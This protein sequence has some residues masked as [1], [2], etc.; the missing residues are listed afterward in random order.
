V[1]QIV[2]RGIAF[3]AFVLLARILGVEAIGNFAYVLSLCALLNLFVEFGTNQFL[4]K[5]VASGSEAVQAATIANIFL[6]K[7]S[8]FAIGIVLLLAI[9][10]KALVTD[11]SVLNFTLGYVIF[12]GVAQIGI[13]ILNGQKQFVKAHAFIFSYEIARSVLLLAFLFFT[14]DLKFVPLI[15]VFCAFTYALVIFFFVLRKNFSISG[16]VKNRDAFKISLVSYYKHTYLFFVAAIAY[17]LYFRVDMILLKRLST[18]VEL[19]V[20]S[21]AYKF[22][23]VF[24]FVPAIL[25]G[26][27]FPS[28][29]EY[30][31]K[32]QVS[33]MKDYLMRFQTQGVV[34]ISSLVILIILFSNFIITVFFGKSF[35]GS[36]QIM[37]ILFL[38]S[39][40]YCFNFIYPVLLNSTGNEK[41]SIYIFAAGFAINFFLNYFLQP[42][43]GAKA[44]AL[45]TLFSECIVTVLYYVYLRKKSL[46]VV[47]GKALALTVC[48]IILSSVWIVAADVAGNMLVSMLVFFGFLVLVFFFFKKEVHHYL[49][50]SAAR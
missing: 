22:F 16:L 13:S 49:I 4:I 18:P 8:Q 20:Y 48:C 34:L 30:Y 11:F 15:Y 39:F 38:T 29:V 24:L 27:I 5:Q 9:E 6:L 46:S 2:S 10:H 42:L 21:T 43:Y 40:L 12:E 36:V 1:F 26:L 32:N 35:S 37:Q 50:S 14:R 31:H 3:F 28:V 41:Y 17:Q 44:A 33:Q 25:S 45:I 23:E 7:L 47:S 19:G